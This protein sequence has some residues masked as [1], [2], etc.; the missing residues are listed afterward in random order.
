MDGN[1]Q[2]QLICDLCLALIYLSGWEEKVP[3]DKLVISAW[4]GYDFGILDRLKS[5]DLVDFSYKAKSLYLT[6]TG[7]E[8]ARQILKKLEQYLAK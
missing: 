6:S 1:K 2:N 8:K 7:E 5:E 3:G 4:K